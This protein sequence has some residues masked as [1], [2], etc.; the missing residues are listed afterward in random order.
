MP[1]SKQIAIIGK[2]NVGSSLQRGLE[3]IG[4]DVRTVGK[5]PDQVERLAKENEIVILAVPFGER[6][7]AIREA[8]VEN[9]NGKILVDVTNALGED[10][11]FALDPR[12]ESGAEQVRDMVGRDVRVV[13]AFNT[14]FAEQMDK[15]NVNGEPLSVFVASEDDQARETVMELARDMGFDPVDAGGLENARWLE[16]L[17]MLNITLGYQVQH[18]TDIGFRLARAGGEKTVRREKGVQKTQ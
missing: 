17:A 16:T 10:G 2:G 3:R 8:G 15:G 6:E 7:Q 1:A 12:K 4:Y 14:I 18:G 5:E 9:L 11:Q 13:K